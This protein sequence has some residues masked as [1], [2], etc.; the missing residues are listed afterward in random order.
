MKTYIIEICKHILVDIEIRNRYNKFLLIFIDICNIFLT[1][2]VNIGRYKYSNI[3]RYN[4]F[5]KHRVA[6]HISIDIR[7]WSHFFQFGH[8]FTIQ[9]VT[10]SAVKGWNQEQ[11]IIT[12]INAA[13]DLKNDWAVLQSSSRNRRYVNSFFLIVSEKHACNISWLQRK[14]GLFWRSFENLTFGRFSTFLK[15][16]TTILYSSPYAWIRTKI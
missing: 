13:Q 8:Y 6:E 2:E 5:K 9:K 11:C 4:N 15:C 10:V 3:G 16:P 1:L 7:S 12:L 14:K